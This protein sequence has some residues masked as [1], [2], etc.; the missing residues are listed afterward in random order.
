MGHKAPVAA[1]V[2]QFLTSMFDK[3]RDQVFQQ[4]GQG[5]VKLAAAKKISDI[6]FPFPYT[7]VRNQQSQW[8]SCFAVLSHWLDA[9]L[10][11]MCQHGEISP[12]A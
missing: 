1:N 11:Q 5:V 7:Q 4:L 8:L 2:E 9:G 12:D 3:Q 10:V 6:P